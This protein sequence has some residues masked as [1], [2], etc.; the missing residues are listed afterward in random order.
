MKIA[1]FM[2]TILEQGGGLEKY[3][4]ETASNFSEKYNEDSID[5]VTLDEKFTVD[6]IKV[7]NL[8]Y[9][10]KIS[11]KNIYRETTES[12][13]NRLGKAGYI[14]VKNFK[15]LL[16]V[17][18][19]YD[20]IYSKNE[21]LEAAIIKFFLGYKNLPPIVFGVHTPHHYPITKS[22]QSK[23]HNLLYESYFYNFLCSGIKAFHTSN[24]DSFDR[25]TN[26]FP[27]KKVYL[28]YYPFE[29]E[30]FLKSIKETDFEIE[31]K[32]ENFNILWLA[33]MT[34]QKGIYD[35]INLISEINKLPISKKIVWHIGGSGQP[36]YEEA[37]KDLAKNFSNVKLYGHIK[38]TNVAYILK[39]MD[40]FISTSKW[41]V[42]PFNILEAQSSDIPVL[43]YSI[44]GPE[45]TIIDKKTGILA[46]NFDDYKKYLIEI[47]ENK[48]QFSNISLN[49]KQKFDPEQIYKNLMG[50]FANIKNNN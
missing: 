27:D 17:L 38:N 29:S 7:L 35:L 28:I 43:S 4:I 3:L 45:D 34:E 49:T 44:P 30:K 22:L 37:L 39:K 50:M 46:N 8:Y 20:V 26:Q 36:I 31:T 40:L 14:N 6:L 42:S 48:H 13:K 41:E 2:S 15:E 33:R 12:I 1:F 11:G 5:I 16:E 24:K 9:F 25:L 19:K 21:I 47:V 32:K 10:T 23:L 18:K